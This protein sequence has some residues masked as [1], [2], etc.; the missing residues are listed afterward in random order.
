M[1]I[2]ICFPNRPGTFS[3]KVHVGRRPPRDCGGFLHRIAAIAGNRLLLRRLTGYILSGAMGACLVCNS[4]IAAELDDT[5]FQAA[6][7]YVGQS[8]D[9]A[10]HNSDDFDALQG[11]ANGYPVTDYPYWYFSRYSYDNKD[12]Y[13][14]KVNYI[15]HLNTNFPLEG[16]RIRL[17]DANGDV[18]WHIGDIDFYNFNSKG[19]IVAGYDECTDGHAYIAIFDASLIDA[20]YQPDVLL[21]PNSTIDLAPSDF[22]VPDGQPQNKQ[23][24]APWVSVRENGRIYSGWGMYDYVN[25]IFE[26]E[27][28]WGDVEESVSVLPFNRRTITLKYENGVDFDRWEQQGGD[29]STDEHLLYLE[30]GSLD[31]EKRINV[32]KVT[33]ENAWYRVQASSIDTLPFL[34]EHNAEEEPEG[35]SY[36]DMNAYGI[37]VYNAGMPRAELHAILLNNDAGPDNV[38]IKHYTSRISVDAAYA[39]NVETGQPDKPFKTVAGA[40]S[41]AWDGSIVNIKGG[42]YPEYPTLAKPW[43][44]LLNAE[45]GSAIIGK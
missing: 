14:Y 17:P 16:R 9:N 36:F 8:A 15:Y 19:Y 33:D 18:C 24:R 27:I 11:V 30:Y 29:F 6:Y 3:G 38:W 35:L 41:I 37:D 7:M 40:A 23:P 39:S 12:T 10:D 4:A 42:N 1:A 31:R 32:F 44:F 45:G 26:Y 5:G 21:Y 34:F 22:P 13:I 2:H 25:E 43:P 28:D 20:S